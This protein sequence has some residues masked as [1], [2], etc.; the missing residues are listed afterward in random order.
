M[1]RPTN[2]LS[3]RA[4]SPATATPPPPPPTPH[5]TSSV[6]AAEGAGQLSGSGPAATAG[7]PNSAATSETPTGAKRSLRFLRDACKA[8]GLSNNGNKATLAKSPMESTNARR[9][10][11][12]PL[13]G[14][15]D[16]SLAAAASTEQPA[17]APA[18]ARRSQ[19]PP[20]TKH[21]VGR[22]FHVMS[23]PDIASCVIACR[24]P[25]TRQQLDAGH[26][27]RDVW[28]AVV[29]EKFT[30]TGNKFAVP[31][32]CSA[33]EVSPNLHPYLRPGQKLRTKFAE[34]SQLIL[35]AACRAGVKDHVHRAAFLSF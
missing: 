9:A 29:P 7:S 32:S 27:K 25:L 11:V 30:E 1:G 16:S 5:P 19:S 13:G 2:A 24:G 34:G 6:S 12:A 26:A 35:C 17:A 18:L 22:L 31:D 28:A 33:Y 4:P 23:M 15:D 10:D 14:V 3:P 20:F 21:Q 8:A